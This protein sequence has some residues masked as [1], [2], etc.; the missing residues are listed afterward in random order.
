MKRCLSRNSRH[1]IAGSR[2]IARRGL[3][4]AGLLV[5]VLL[6]TGCEALQPV[7]AP[8]QPGTRQ[9]AP[10][11]PDQTRPA[12]GP[13]PL[14]APTASP[15]SPAPTTPPVAEPTL[16]EQIAEIQ[17]LLAAKGYDPGPTDGLYGGRTA[18]AIARY[19]RDAGLRENM[20]TR[21]LLAHLKGPPEAPALPTA[22][23]AVR[24]VEAAG[25]LVYEAG[26]HYVYSDGEVH[27]VVRVDSDTVVWREAGGEIYTTLHAAGLP[28]LSWR[29]GE[30]RG[31]STFDRASAT[32]WPPAEGPG[33]TFDV[34]V[35][36][37]SGEDAR[38][39]MES[40]WTCFRERQGPM[41]IMAGRFDVEVFFCERSP[42]PAGAWQRR[43]WYFAPSVGHNIMIEDRDAAGVVLG[44]RELVAVLPGGRDWQP[45]IRTGLGRAIQDALSNRLVGRSTGWQTPVFP[46]RFVIKVTGEFKGPGGKPC[47]SYTV[48]RIRGAARRDYPAAACK[49]A[50][51][52]RW[53]VPGVE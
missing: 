32:P 46:D 40:R 18:D 8:R 44:R 3:A 50:G 2:C 12:P 51:S 28:K 22:G 15:A 30:W 35:E 49:D 26:D 6:A 11:E 52:S 45:A 14:L 41:D 13:A 19:R 38:L 37:W 9:P 42:A 23:L 7:W 20:A 17:K 47:R 36:E 48:T 53:I 10:A 33:L 31:Q 21:D 5:C 27:S 39:T 25:W 24:P 43:Y 34:R 29:A 1:G 16:R 4:G